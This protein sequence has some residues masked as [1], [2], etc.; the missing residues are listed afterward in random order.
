MEKNELCRKI[1]DL[2]SGERRTL[3]YSLI[4]ENGSPLT[5]EPLY[6]VSIVLKETDEQSLAVGIST[7]REKVLH[8]IDMLATGYVTP[9][10]L[11]DIVYDY[12]CR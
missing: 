10:S 2:G 6:G 1:I 8:L 3:I 7:D 5:D 12:I 4:T 11:Q 9:M